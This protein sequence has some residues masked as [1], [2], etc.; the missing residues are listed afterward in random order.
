M[1]NLVALAYVKGYEPTYRDPPEKFDPLR[2][3]FHGHSR[4]SEMTRSDRRPM[5]SISDPQ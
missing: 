3:G 4:S 2:P 1:P 5:T